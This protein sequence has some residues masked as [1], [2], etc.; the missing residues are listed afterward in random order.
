MYFTCEA[1]IMQAAA[2]SFATSVLR[3]HR[4]AIGNENDSAGLQRL[5][6]ATRGKVT[7]F[8]ANQSSISCSVPLFALQQL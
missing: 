6:V 4:G 1:A 8:E 2:P 3:E 5:Q 7:Y